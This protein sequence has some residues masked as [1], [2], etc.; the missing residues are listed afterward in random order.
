MAL[1]RPFDQP[2]LGLHVEQDVVDD[3]PG[4][5]LGA[6]DL[7]HRAPALLQLGAG[8]VGHALG[9]GLEPLVDLLRRGQVLV[10]VAR[11][12]AQVEDDAVLDGLVELVGVDEA[13]EGLDA[14][15]LVGLEQRRAGEA[16]EH[17]PGQ[18]LLHRVVHLAG[19]GAVRLV[20]E[21]EDVALGTEV[22][23]DLGVQL[24]DEV[25]L[26][27]V[28][29]GLV[30]GAAELVDQRADQPLVDLVER[31]EQVGAALGAVDRTR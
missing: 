12:V 26:G 25:V 17:R 29:A 18:E 16:D 30:I 27:L 28:A 23:R 1:P 22:L 5:W 10:D 2:R 11:L 21:D 13:A 6:D 24:L 7:L 14:R 19:L 15:G 3:L 20:D 4:A 9:L 8:Q 31:G